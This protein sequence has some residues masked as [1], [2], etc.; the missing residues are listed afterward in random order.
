M[1]RKGPPYVSI[2][3]D[4]PLDSRWT[5]ELWFAWSRILGTCRIKLAC[6][7][8][9]WPAAVLRLRRHEAAS[10]LAVAPNRVRSSLDQLAMVASISVRHEADHGGDL[11]T[12]SVDNYAEYQKL[13]RPTSAP[14]RSQD[15]EPPSVP[16]SLRPSE[17]KKKTPQ[18]PAPD[19]AASPPDP[20]PEG[21]QLDLTPDGA[22][23]STAL[24]RRAWPGVQ[25]A[26]AA[27]DPRRRPTALGAARLRTMAAILREL[28]ARAPGVLVELVHG[29]MATHDRHGDGWNPLDNFTP[30]TCWRAAHR[31]KHL[32]AHDRALA[33]RGA[34]PWPPR[35]RAGAANRS[36]HEPVDDRAR[37]AEVD[38]LMERHR[39]LYRSTA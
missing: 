14:K 31:A 29:Y 12:I 27:Y 32:D 18:P 36:A 37:N 21:R 25:D 19:G 35:G 2:Q 9:T 13:G 22:E 20:P 3:A 5:A 30:E 11:W 28:P 23:G 8:E 10:I 24:A 34:P 26:F 38:R 33:E 16:P 1:P 15:R 7:A 6:T 4:A 17:E 39:R